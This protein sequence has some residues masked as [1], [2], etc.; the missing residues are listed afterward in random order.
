MKY[1][2]IGIKGAGMSTLAQILSDLGNKVS[3]YD[4]VRDYKFTQVGL[5]KRN[6]TVYCDQNHELEEDMIVTHSMAISPDHPELKRAK[7][8]GLTIK[9]YSEL[10]G[11]IIALFTSISVAGTHGK[12]TT[13]SMIRHILENALG[14]N[15]FIGSGSGSAKKENKYFVIESDEFN[16][17]FL[18]YHPQYAVITN[19]EKEHMECYKDLEDI[20]NSYSQFASQTEK[21]VV[22]CGDDE[23]VRKLKTNTKIFYYGLKEENDIVIKNITLAETGN[24]FDIFVENEM[25]GHFSVPLFGIHMVFNAAAAIFMCHSLGVDIE[26]IKS[27]LMTFK[28]EEHRFAEQQVGNT[29]I[30]DDY[31]HHPTEIKKTLEAIRQ[32]YPSKKVV[33]VFKPNTYSRTRD[34]EQGFIEALNAADQAY[35]TEIECNRE[36]PEDYPGVTSQRLVEKAEN[37]KLLTSD[38]DMQDLKNEKGNVICFMGCAYLSNLIEN[39]KKSI[40]E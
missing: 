40:D 36:K 35:I 28:N 7:E 13:S 37:T 6:I 30:I 12:T 5:D 24:E 15:Y 39:F 33:V 9:K 4:D 1:Y 23:N 18:D 22:A 26:K 29:V 25:L 21:F 2:C 3:G 32:K 27:L 11:E 16:K 19:I 31:A 38:N 20:V 34:F 8:K 10:V 17:H 14:C